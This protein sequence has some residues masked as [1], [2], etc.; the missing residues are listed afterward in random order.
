MISIKKKLAKHALSY[1]NLQKVIFFD[2]S[3]TIYE[4]C[5]IVLDICY[6]TENSK[7]FAWDICGNVF[8]KNLLKRNG[9]MI[10][11]PELN[12]NWDF[13]YMGFGFTMKNITVDEEDVE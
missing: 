4:L 1:I 13:K 3:T 2:V 10:S 7:Q 8:I 5:N 6:K 12:N 11:Y 9:Y